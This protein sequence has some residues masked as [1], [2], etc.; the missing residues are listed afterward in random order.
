MIQVPAGVK[1][2]HGAKAD[3]WFTHI[4]VEVLGTDTHNEWV[5]PVTDEHYNNLNENR[6]NA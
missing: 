1:H 5:E 4:A 2:W 3:S 6:S